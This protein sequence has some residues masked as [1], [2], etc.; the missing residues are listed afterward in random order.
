MNKHIA[1]IT[2]LLQKD[3]IAAGYG[4][5]SMKI[6]KT[7][8]KVLGPKGVSTN[9]VSAISIAAGTALSKVPNSH[10]QVIGGALR[11]GGLAALGNSLV[12]KALS[13][14]DKEEGK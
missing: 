2:G 12:E 1:N 11:V 8:S 6:R 14:K 4:L 13:K 5:V 3:A 10:V 9:G 7:L